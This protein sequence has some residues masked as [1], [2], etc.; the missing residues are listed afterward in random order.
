MLECMWRKRGRGR[1]HH[2]CLHVHLCLGTFRALKGTRMQIKS[3]DKVNSCCRQK[4]IQKKKEKKHHPSPRHQYHTQQKLP[5][6]HIGKRI[7]ILQIVKKNATRNTA[8]I[9]RDFFKLV[10]K[11]DKTLACYYFKCST[12]VSNKSRNSPIKQQ[13]ENNQQRENNKGKKRRRRTKL[14]ARDEGKKKGERSRKSYIATKTTTT[15][16]KRSGATATYT[17]TKLK[18]HT[19]RKTNKKMARASNLLLVTSYQLLI[20]YHVISGSVQ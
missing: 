9:D 15:T 11:K 20:T 13:S 6:L 19:K 8:C 12:R 1:L 3:E 14:V 7:R 5:E 2:L 16:K 18:A 4:M 10:K 17:R